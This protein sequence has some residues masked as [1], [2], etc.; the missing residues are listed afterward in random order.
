MRARLNP[1]EWTPLCWKKARY[2]AWLGTAANRIDLPLPVL[3][4]TSID[5]SKTTGDEAALWSILTCFAPSLNIPQR[6]NLNTTIPSL[7]YALATGSCFWQVFSR[8]APDGFAADRDKSPPRAFPDPIP[9]RETG[10]EVGAETPRI[11]A[12]PAVPTTMKAPTLQSQATDQGLGWLLP[13]PQP[14]SPSPTDLQ[15]NARWLNC[16]CS[17]GA[18]GRANSVAVLVPIIRWLN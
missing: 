10:R 6:S 9:S 12:E 17:S 15:V 16:T 4:H 2:H 5:N 18:P 3:R 8:W 14:L 7:G 11:G 13:A 1:E